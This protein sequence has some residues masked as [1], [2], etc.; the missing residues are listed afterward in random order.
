MVSNYNC[1][2]SRSKVT[3]E[4]KPCKVHVDHLSPSL[5]EQGKPNIGTDKV[6]V[7][8]PPGVEDEPLVS[9]ED[10]GKHD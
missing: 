4:A 5:D 8:V 7:D 10:K 2:M 6:T 3:M 1:K 9:P